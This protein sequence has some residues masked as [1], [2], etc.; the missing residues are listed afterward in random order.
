MRFSETTV[1]GVILIEPDVHRDERGYFLETFHAAKYAAAGLSLEFVQDNHSSSVA[2]TLRGLHMQV[3]R[4]QGKLVRVV[5]G[6]IWDVAVDVLRVSPTYAQWTAE[7]L[8]ADNFKQLYIPPGCAH[9]FCVLSPSAQIEYKCTE[10]YDPADELGIAWDDPSLAI[11]WP[12]RD[13]LMSDRD[14]RHRRMNELLHRLPVYQAD[15]K[16]TPKLRGSRAG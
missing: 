9:G 16:G 1:S 14:R 11:P 4:P 10:L 15:R 5:E 12:V 3:Q 6:S 2:N 7:E 8:S 13:P